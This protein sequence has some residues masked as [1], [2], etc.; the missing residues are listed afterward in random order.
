MGRLRGGGGGPR[1]SCDRPHHLARAAGLRAAPASATVPR[2]ASRITATR[3]SSFDAIA[4][5]EMIEAVGE[6]N[7]PTY[8]RVLHDRLEARRQRR[9]PGHHHR[10]AALSRLPP[11][12]RFHPAL[13]FSGRHAADKGDP[14][15]AGGARRTDLRDGADLRPGLCPDAGPVAGAFRGVVERHRQARLRRDSSA[16]AGATISATARRASAKA[17]STSASTVSAAP[18]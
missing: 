12:G 4:S 14:R 5:I 10:R 6:A 17:R 7:W 15:R 2:S 13:H 16:A 1:P 3:R 8:F 18:R 9:G 11:Q